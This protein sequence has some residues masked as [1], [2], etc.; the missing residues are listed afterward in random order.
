MEVEVKSAHNETL[1]TIKQRRSIRLFT[2]EE[3]S[4]QD[5]NL[6]LLAANEAPSAHNQQ[7]WK[8]VMRDRNRTAQRSLPIGA[9]LPN[10]DLPTR[11]GSAFPGHVVIAIANTG[12]LIQDSTLKSKGDGPIFR[13]MRF[14]SSATAV[15]N[16]PSATSD[17]PVYWHHHP[18]KMRFWFR[19]Q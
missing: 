17:Q 18:T 2:K 14:R 3:V 12:E 8:V 6:L 5:I 7:S 16:L 11:G 15:Q 13:T 9:S 10:L 19:R 1:Q 4:D